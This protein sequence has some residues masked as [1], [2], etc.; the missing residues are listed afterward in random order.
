MK[1]IGM[2]NEDELS[3]KGGTS[4]RFPISVLVCAAVSLLGSGADAR[5]TRLQT[6]LRE[7]VADGMAF[8]A[9]GPYEKLRV[10]VNPDDP[11][12]AMVFDLDKAPRNENGMVEFSADIFMLKPVDPS[13]VPEH[14]SARIP[15]RAR[16]CDEVL[17]VLARSG[18]TQETVCVTSDDLTTNNPDTTPTEAS[19][20]DLPPGA[21]N[22]SNQTGPNPPYQTPIAGPVAGIQLTGAMAGRSEARWVIRMPHVWNR[23]LVVGVPGGFNSE[24]S[25]DHQW[26][27]FVVQQGYAYVASNKG[28]YNR[29]PT[30]PATDPFA[31]PAGAY[32]TPAYGQSIRAYVLDEDRSFEQIFDWVL[33][34]TDVAKIAVHANFRGHAKHT[35]LVGSSM[36]GLVVRRLLAVS[37]DR[38]DGGIDATGPFVSTSNPNFPMGTNNPRVARLYHAYFDGG[39]DHDSPAYQALAALGEPPDIAS[40]P[41]G[42]FLYET[43]DAIWEGINGCYWPFFFDP[44]YRGSYLDYDYAARRLELGLD[45]FVET[46]SSPPTLQ[47]RMISV[48]GTLDSVVPLVTARDFRNQVVANGYGDRHRLYEVQN[49]NHVDS[50]KQPPINLAALEFLQP[51]LHQSFQLLVNWVE[52]S[53]EPPAGQCIPRGQE[54]VLEPRE[55]GRPEHCEELLADDQWIVRDP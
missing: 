43:S 44:T 5:V 41:L 31:C 9:A 15:H 40:N 22:P 23:R 25:H 49:G 4:F 3:M 27:D 35:Y 48:H 42:H 8:G 12:N 14:H 1:N 11:H 52:R 17:R 18:L 32:G 33:A 53:Q 30:D 47:R 2:I 37:P 26:S 6:T 36:G 54:I 10:E 34:T 21:F 19:R 38:F 24:Y 46:A 16:G 39:F 20:P 45:P 29:R 7:V 55:S 13:S 28:F 50:W 51:H